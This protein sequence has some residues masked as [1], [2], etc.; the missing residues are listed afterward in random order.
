[1]AWQSPKPGSK[2][3]PGSSLTISLKQ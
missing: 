3:L 2:E 1:V